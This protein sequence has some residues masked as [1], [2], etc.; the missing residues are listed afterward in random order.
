MSPTYESRVSSIPGAMRELHAD[1]L[2]APAWPAPSN[3]R[4]WMTTRRG[5]IS[6]GAYGGTPRA[7]D[8]PSH[9]TGG[10]NLGLGSGDAREAVLANRMRLRAHVPAEPIWLEQVHGVRV[11]DAAS[12]TGLGDSVD[13]AAIEADASYTDA[14]G[15]VCAVLVADCMPVLLCDRRGTRVAAA[16]AGWRGLAAGVLE[17][18][19]AASGF[20][21]AETLAWIGPAIG[22]GRFEVGDDVRDAFLTAEATCG[23][24]FV[25]TADGKWLADLPLLARMRL[26]A[27]G[28]TEVFESGHCTASDEARFYSYRRD[29]ATGR[30][31]ALIWIDH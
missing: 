27:R 18:T 19:L 11:V 1:D 24:A 22:P 25:A 8:A 16:H 28:V 26:S 2:I 30:M 6:V 17:A 7:S 31:A 10:L 14:R 29:G 12:V 4:A 9:A 3:V 5:G 23:A 20:D 21:P 15:V 13:D